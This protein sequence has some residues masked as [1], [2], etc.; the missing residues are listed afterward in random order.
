MNLDFNML[1]FSHS[2]SDFNFTSTHRF[3]RA[4]DPII[5]PGAQKEISY[6]FLDAVRKKITAFS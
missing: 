6:Y 2:S 1:Q 3:E 4:W 5:V